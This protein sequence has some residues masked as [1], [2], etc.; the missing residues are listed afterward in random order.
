MMKQA[1]LT[2]ALD[3]IKNQAQAG[4]AGASDWANSIKGQAQA[5]LGNAGSSI[6]A[7]YESQPK[8]TR[9]A[10]INS[11]IG[12]GTGAAIG[13][14]SALLNKSDNG[15]SAVQPA[16]MGAL[17]GGIAGGGLTLGRDML[18]NRIR[19]PGIPEPKPKPILTQLTDPLI[20]ATGDNLGAIAGLSLAAAK[21]PAR[22]ALEHIG[23]GHS[24]RAMAR[25]A[26]RMPK[27]KKLSLALL[28]IGMGLGVAAH[29]AIRGEY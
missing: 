26:W 22:G 25:R 18:K 7:W 20:R 16:L 21:T 6:K 9:D 13:G 1:D 2:D 29:R 17:F 14:G 5:G 3:T 24:V 12:A 23:K 28:P 10:V 19:L 11:L 8:E 4:L 27:G 15:R